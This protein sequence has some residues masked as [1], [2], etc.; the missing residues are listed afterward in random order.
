MPLSSTPVASNTRLQVQAQKPPSTTDIMNAIASLSTSQSSQFK[1]LN[2]SI[3][4]LSSKVAELVAEN[5]SLRADVSVLC[6]RVDH[7]ES[8]PVLSNNSSAVIFRESTERSKIEFNAIAYGV[9][10]SAANTAALRFKDDLLTLGNHLTKLS[11]PVPTDSKLIRLGNGN[12]KKPRPLKIICQSKTD[13]SQLISNFNSQ[14][15]NGGLPEPGFR[16]VRDKTTLE[17]ELLRKAHADLQLKIDG[18]SSDFTIYYVNGLPSV[19]KAGP[20]N[21]NSRGGSNR[22]PKIWLSDDISNSELGFEGYLIFRCDRNIRTSNCTRGGG[23]LIAVKKE[24]RPTLITTPYDTCEHVFVRLTLPSGFS[25]FLAGVYLPPGA[26]HFVYESHVEALDVVWRSNNYDLGLVCGDFNLPNVNWPVSDSGLVYSGTITNKVRVVG[27]LFSLLH[28][29]QKN[30]ILNNTGSLLDLI[31]TNNESTQVFQ[32]AVT[33]VPCDVYHPALSISCPFPSVPSMLAAQHTY[34]DYKNA[35]YDK[36][37]QRLENIDW[38]NA[39]G[40]G[41]VDQT[42]DFLQETLLDCIREHV[43]M[44]NF[45]NSTF[46]KWVS[47]NLKSLLFKKKQL[48][49]LYKTLGGH[50]RYLIF[51]RLRAQFCSKRG[52]STIPDEVFLGESKASSDQVASLFASHFSSVYGDPRFISNALSDEFTNQQFSFLPSNLSISIDEVNEALNSLSHVRSSGPDGICAIL[53]YH[54]RASLSSP[55]TL[56][57]NQSLLEGV[58]PSVWKI[59]RV[60]PILKSGNPADVA[61]YRPISSLP[62]LGKLFEYIVL[63][64]IERPLLTTI[65]ID[66]H[67]FFPERST[68]TSLIDFVSYL[69]TAFDLGNQVDVIYTEFSK[70]FDSLDHNALIFILDRLGIG[71]PLLSWFGSYLSDRRQFVRLF[72]KSSDFFRAS[73]GVPQG[74]HLS[75]LL[76]NIFINTMCSAISSCRLLLFADDSKIFLRITTNNDCLTLQNTLDKFTNWCN[77]FN[78]SLNISKCKVMSF[79]RSKSVFSFDYKLGGISIQRVNQVQD[80]GIL[81]VPSLNFS[82]HIDFMTSKSFRVLG[83]I[84]RHSVNFSSANCLLALYKALVRSVIEYGSV[85]WSPYT[86]VDISRIDRVQN[87]F[88]RFAGYCLNIPH[89]PHDYRPVSQALRLDSL[90]ARRDN[91]GIAFIQRLIDGRIDAPRILGELSFRIPKLALTELA[92]MDELTTRV[93]EGDDTALYKK[94]CIKYHN[95]TGNCRDLNWVDY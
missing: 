16:I 43:P 45:R 73:S 20:K 91:F 72:G 88:M 60:T 77:T 65:S 87:C 59:S 78:L 89:E 68:A 18:G 83:F 55:V 30:Q 86:A 69:H 51:S 21:L 33:L 9:P 47:S 44:R 11:V 80:L 1:E 32:A 3:S 8:R 38:Y 64:R 14:L 67:G 94:G 49:K 34:Y 76:F 41:S 95:R 84:R 54:C 48:H 75:P 2:S 39:L 85:V 40:V 71:E 37:I 61:N 27:D 42:A 31:F 82:P 15:R 66:Q 28:F 13:A 79:H 90:S 58:F 35:N 53:L 93:L 57:F 62:L 26:N 19:V 22:R 36:I 10:E 29:V 56:I 46:P 23:S 7:L 50:N 52:V 74:S 25:V 4:G 81:F 92:G 17:R 5:A 70:A 24:L 6:S 63:K 12:A